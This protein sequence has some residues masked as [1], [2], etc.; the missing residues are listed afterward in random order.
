[1]KKLVSR[2][3]LQGELFSEAYSITRAPCHF[4]VYFWF[5]NRLGHLENLEMYL[6]QAFL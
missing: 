6:G 3:W 5:K 2:N 1:M 4:H